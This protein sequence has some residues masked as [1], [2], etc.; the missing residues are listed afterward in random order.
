LSDPS[1]LVASCFACVL[2]LAND[3]ATTHKWTAHDWSLALNILKLMGAGLTG[4]AGVIATLSETKTPDKKHLS[5]AGRALL[6]L[7]IVGFAITLSSQIVEWVKGSYDADEA[8]HQN[9]ITLSEIRRAVTRLDH[10]SYSVTMGL[11]V[12]EPEFKKYRDHLD[13]RI[14]DFIEADVPFGQSSAG[15]RGISKHKDDWDHALIGIHPEALPKKSPDGIATELINDVVPRVAL[16]KRPI[17]ARGFSPN[18][19]PTPDLSLVPTPSPPTLT[20]I[21]D[22]FGGESLRGLTV[23]R[24]GMDVPA[25]RW[26]PSGD[27][28]SIEDLVGAEA[29]I[30]IPWRVPWRND[31]PVQ[32]LWKQSTVSVVFFFNR[33][34]VDL[35]RAAT[36]AEDSDHLR[37]FTYVF[38]RDDFQK[39]R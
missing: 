20:G 4:T 6:S 7:G 32:K 9:A 21:L 2:A 16:Y 8:Q 31:D 17:D 15:I 26:S 14:Q 29:I 19:W 33:Q 37:V 5:R 27:I 23:K 38:T 35:T 10:I 39:A 34:K 25:D 3:G 18:S 22:D 13:T 28:V 11:P 24:D 30:Y 1:T 12:S 36:S